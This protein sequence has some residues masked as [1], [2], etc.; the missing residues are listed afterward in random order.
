MSFPKVVIIIL[1]YNGFQDTTRCLK[2]VLKTDYR[3]FRV[4]VADN[5]SKIDESKILAKK[6]KDK[7]LQFVRFPK[8][9]G[10]SG[11]NNKILRTTTEKYVVLL[12]ND[13]E[14]TPNWLSPLVKVLEDNSKIAVVQPKILWLTN[15]KY[16][17][18]AGACGG[19]IDALGYPFT[20][21]RIFYTQEKDKE[22]YD[23]SCDIVWASGAAM[24]I[25]RRVLGH[26]GLFD[27]R[28]FNYMEE[29]DLCLRIQRSGY[30]I[31]SEPKAIVF[32]KGASTASRNLFKKR[33]WEHRNNLLLIL[34]N[35]PFSR[36]IFIFPARIL[37][38]LLSIPHYLY[39]R[40]IHYA[41]AVILSQFSLIYYLPG[42]LRERISNR[43]NRTKENNPFIVNK[44]IA[45]EYFVTKKRKYAD[46]IKP[47]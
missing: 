10:F 36:L 34:K 44:S 41:M 20:R 15:K 39:I 21:G 13:T 17:D 42:I 19:F 23:V 7:R 45:F 11:G 35:Y 47:K 3:S 1:N 18:Y 12:N 24:I 28:F 43:T 2:S 31:I 16:F 46:I 14:V 30:K 6:F 22:Q 38:E 32:H 4:I 33:F 9:L 26:V 27:E 40:K 37:M 8:N 25:R 29:I 5:G